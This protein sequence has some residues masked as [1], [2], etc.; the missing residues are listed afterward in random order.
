MIGD[1]S[2]M[3]LQY[4]VLCGAKP[5]I[6]IHTTERSAKFGTEFIYNTYIW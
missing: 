2:D 5:E 3:F 1:I 6:C 4:S